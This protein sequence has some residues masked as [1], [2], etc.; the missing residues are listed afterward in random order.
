MRLLRPAQREYR[1]NQR[2]R[3]IESREGLPFLGLGFARVFN[4]ANNYDPEDAQDNEHFRLPDGKE[5]PAANMHDPAP[6]SHFWAFSNLAIVARARPEL[7]LLVRISVSILFIKPSTAELE[8]LTLRSSN[9]FAQ[10]QVT[11]R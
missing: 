11:S 8:C 10:T 5:K 7:S 3:Q 1:F 4:E 9:L 6:G 2:L